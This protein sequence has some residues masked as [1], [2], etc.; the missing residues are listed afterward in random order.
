M[1]RSRAVAAISRSATRWRGRHDPRQWI[2]PGDPGQ[3]PRDVRPS[4]REHRGSRRQRD[5]RAD[6]AAHSRQSPGSSP[7]GG[8]R[9]TINGGTFGTSASG[10]RVTFGVRRHRSWSEKAVVVL[11]PQHLLAN[12]SFSDAADVT[13]TVDLGLPSQQSALLS[14]AFTYRC[15]VSSG[16]ATKLQAVR[17]IGWESARGETTRPAYPSNRY[18]SLWTVTMKT[19][20]D[21]FASTLARREA[22][23]T[24]T[25]RETG[26]A[27]YPQTSSRRR[28]RE[29]ASPGARFGTSPRSASRSIGTGDRQRHERD[30]E[31]GADRDRE[32]RARSG[33]AHAS[34]QDDRARPCPAIYISYNR[35]SLS[36]TGIAKWKVAPSP[37]R[38]SAQ[39]RP[40]WRATIRFT[41]ARPTPVP[42]NSSA[43]CRRWNTP[44]S[45][46]P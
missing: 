3:S 37:G 44:K 2:Q 8:D 11:T 9:V 25:V 13:I 32:V 35:A 33:T 15:P 46:W 28:S 17:P 19:G 45:L 12:P 43:T 36:G 7:A 21:G 6:A 4:G 5:R 30:E 31:P 26:V 40:P 34:V 23:L 1:P 42:S 10:K 20:C 14:Q 22:T 27:S 16:S 39:T 24:S 41:I 29:T 38:P 18:P